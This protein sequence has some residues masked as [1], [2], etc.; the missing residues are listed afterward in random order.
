M[1]EAI[2][3]STICGDCVKVS[4][5]SGRVRIMVLKNERPSMGR[6]FFLVICGYP[7]ALEQGGYFD[8]E[9]GLVFWV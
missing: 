6:A 7:V 2:S 1:S 4:G 5:S 3:R 8:V 9:G